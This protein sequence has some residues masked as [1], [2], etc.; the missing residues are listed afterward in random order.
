VTTG[1]SDHYPVEQVQLQ[2]F[3]GKGW[4]RFGEVLSGN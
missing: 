4:V 2:R 1:P 3:D